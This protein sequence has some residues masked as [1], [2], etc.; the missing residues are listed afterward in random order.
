MPILVIVLH[1]AILLS[2]AAEVIVEWNTRFDHPSV[3]VAAIRTNQ[4]PAIHHFFTF[5][6]PYCPASTLLIPPNALSLL[7]SVGIEL[8]HADIKSPEIPDNQHQSV[9]SIQVGYVPLSI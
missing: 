3:S 2:S 6:Y 9:P 8:I 5:T 1:K 7:G 4:F